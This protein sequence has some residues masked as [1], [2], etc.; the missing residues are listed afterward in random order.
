MAIHL[1]FMVEACILNGD[2]NTITD[3]GEKILVIIGKV[4]RDVV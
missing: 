1:N 2:G 4:G 3:N